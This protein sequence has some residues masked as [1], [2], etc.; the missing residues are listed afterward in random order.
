MTA[1]TQIDAP[2]G[3]PFIEMRRVFAAPRALVYR[4]FFEPDLLIQWLGPRKYRMTIETMEVRDGGRYRYTHHDDQGN[5]WVFHGV[6]HGN[7][8]EDGA[9]QTFEFEGAPGHVSLD[10]VTFE[11]RDG[12]TVVRTH[13]VFQSVEARDAMVQSG[14]AEGVNDGY[15]RLEALIERLA[16]PA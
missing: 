9:V 1:K 11:E 4:A 2:S 12:R 8:T 5:A 7:P 13:S 15:D 14:M 16:V 6:Y 10:K 3:V